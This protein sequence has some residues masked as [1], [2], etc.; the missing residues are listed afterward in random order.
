MYP[1][2]FIVSKTSR[3]NITARCSCTC[4]CSCLWRILAFL[5]GIGILMLHHPLAVY[6]ADA[7]SALNLTQ[8]ERDFLHSHLRFR[9]HVE[10]G[11]H[12]F[13]YVDQQGRAR[14]FGVDLTD[15]IARRLGI[16][17]ECVRLQP[18]LKICARRSRTLTL[19]RFHPRARVSAWPR[20][21][22]KMMVPE[23]F[24]APTALCTAPR[25]KEENK[26]VTEEENM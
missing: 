26:V 4:H 24:N 22:L 14:G 15:I 11:C 17:M 13:A 7:S 5:L 10:R 21:A 25:M 19:I 1:A 9:V 12:P 23:C 16:E 18:W 8:A 3:L 6:A 2:D 20:C